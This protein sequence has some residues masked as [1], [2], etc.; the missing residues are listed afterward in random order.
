MATK[1][2]IYKALLNIANMDTNYYYEHNLTLALHP[3]ET[4]ERLMARV[5]AFIL[6]A[7]ED[8]GFC[9]GIS[10]DDEPDL[11]EKSLDGEIQLWIDL[12]QPD[13]KRIKKACNRSKRV[14]IYTYQENM[15]QPWF[16]QMEKVINRWNNLSIIYLNIDGDIEELAKRGMNLQCNISDEE[17]TLIGDDKSMIIT[18]N[19]WK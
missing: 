1:A 13:E 19:K 12:G 14:I 4:E 15:A 17:L 11:W 9:K 8:L 6:N 10:E 18:Q 5:V 2:T 16:K 3:S 7:N